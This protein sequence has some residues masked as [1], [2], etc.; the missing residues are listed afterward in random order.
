MNWNFIPLL[1]DVECSRMSA[2]HFYADAS[3]HISPQDLEIFITA[4]SWYLN[5]IAFSSHQT[6]KPLSSR[7]EVLVTIQRPQSEV[8]FG[9]RHK[10]AMPRDPNY[11]RW[12]LPRLAFRSKLTST[13]HKDILIICEYICWLYN[14]IWCA[15]FKIWDE[16]RLGADLSSDTDLT[17]QCV[18]RVGRAGYIKCLKKKKKS[19]YWRCIITKRIL[20]CH[21]LQWTGIPAGRPRIL[22]AFW[23]LSLTQT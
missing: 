19:N 4:I 2:C 21:L 14:S 6:A 18:R 15:T 23:D 20:N 22:S 1:H 9:I 11:Q 8:V 17:D 12:R 13:L 16:Q 7:S 10:R 5:F 3:L